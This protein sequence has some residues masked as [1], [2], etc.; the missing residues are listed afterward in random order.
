M[1]LPVLIMSKRIKYF[2]SSLLGAIAFYLYLGLPFE[3]RYYGLMLLLVMVVFCFWFGLGII[4]E[5]SI[6]TRIM[7]ILLPI[8][9]TIGFGLFSVLLPINWFNLL[10]L[11]I[12][13]GVILYIMFLAENVFLVAIGFRTVP[14]Y[15]AAYT[16]SLILVLLVS[17][18]VFDSL[19][20]F[21]FPFWGNMLATM[22]LGLLIFSYQY[23]AIAIELPD[24]G[25]QKGK[26]PYILIPSLLLMEVAGILSFW[27][28]GIFK[29]SVYLVAAIYVITGLLQA[30]IRDRL[31]RGVVTTYGYI[32]MAVILAVILATNWG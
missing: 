10:G 17:F 5:A 29:G 26:W 2:I 3:S 18:F 12:F 22:I 28:V 9:W 31:F 21:K 4:F 8:L 27:P 25:R 6:D 32:G 24:D 23:W 7:V 14:L 16:V 20:S 13:F 1:F 30:E 19:F 11:S 15:R